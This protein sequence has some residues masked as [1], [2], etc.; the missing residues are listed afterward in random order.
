MVM[1][2]DTSA[3]VPLAILEPGT[4]VVRPLLTGDEGIVVWWS[5]RVECLSALS[6][7][8][9]D[10][11][12]SAATARDARRVIAT[13]AQ[14]WTEVTPTESV[15]KRAER[16]LSA[17]FYAGCSAAQRHREGGAQETV[18]WRGHDGLEEQG[19]SVETEV[20]R[21]GQA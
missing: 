13:L 4:A 9:R 10:K 11:Q 19:G 20:D 16:L 18:G 12:V 17:A 6:R 7:R 1:F 3:I 15:R 5:T 14:A 2:W 21:H 8:L